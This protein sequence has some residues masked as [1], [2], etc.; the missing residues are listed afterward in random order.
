MKF[1]AMILISLGLV[2]SASAEVTYRNTPTAVVSI[3][4]K[5]FVSTGDEPRYVSRCDSEFNTEKARLEGLGLTL[6]GEVACRYIRSPHEYGT[7]GAYGEIHF[8]R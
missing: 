6:L 3:P 4:A 7:P 1:L 5:G 8:I 2:G